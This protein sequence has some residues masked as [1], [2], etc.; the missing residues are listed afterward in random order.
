LVVLVT[1]A[2]VITV[3]VVVSE[4]TPTALGKALGKALMK[5]SLVVVVASRSRTRSIALEATMVAGSFVPMIVDSLLIRTVH[6]LHRL[7]AGS[8][9]PSR[10]MLKVML[11]DFVIIVVI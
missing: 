7:A 5:A 9:T 3:A 2:V 6:L 11:K 10:T 8:I 4:R 1:A